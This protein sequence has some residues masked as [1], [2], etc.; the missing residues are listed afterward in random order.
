M[1]VVIAHKSGL[2]AYELAQRNDRRKALVVK[3]VAYSILI[4]AALVYILPFVLSA[5]SSFKS[6]PDIS[7]HPVA[8]KFDRAMGSPS[9]DGVRGL[10]RDSITFPRWTINSIFVTTVVVFGRLVLASFGGYALARMKFRGQRYFF[11]LILLV[12]GIPHI[13]LEIGRASCR[14]RVCMLV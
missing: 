3:I 9:L 2:D 6:D 10:N 12:M 14:E 11:S 13:V 1:S 4:L 5:I 8:F 7:K